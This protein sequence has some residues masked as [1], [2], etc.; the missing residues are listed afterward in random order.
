MSI[1]KI[2]TVNRFGATP[3]G[4]RPHTQ[5]S[6]FRVKDK[7]AIKDPSQDK[8]ELN[9]HDLWYR[10]AMSFLFDSIAFLINSYFCFGP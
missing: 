3:F 8:S 2:A 7:E 1:K 9:I 10:F 6:T 5:G 4:L